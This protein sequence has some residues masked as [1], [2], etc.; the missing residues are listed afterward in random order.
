M[1]EKVHPVKSL[2][3][4]GIATINFATILNYLQGIK[5]IEAD[6]NIKEVITTLC[7]GVTDAKKREEFE[8]VLKKTASEMKG[9]K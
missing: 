7:Q 3:L 1:I 8:R 5:G 9:T 2:E 4:L 6:D